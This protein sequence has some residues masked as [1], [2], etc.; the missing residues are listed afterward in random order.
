MNPKVFSLKEANL[1]IPR[2]DSLTTCLLTK[3]EKMQ[4]KHDQLL[5]LDLIAGEKVHNPKTNDGKDYLTKSAEL[6]ALILSFEDDILE[7]NK[8]G[9]YLR[10][11][12]KG[13]VDFFS[14]QKNELIYL[15]WQRGEER[16]SFYHDVDAHFSKRKNLELP[17]L[18]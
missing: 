8:L 10:D 14:I 16:V 5:V 1:M 3:K 18:D 17:F 6:E 11:I 15:N 13:S 12:E 2:L 4:K 7:I 9:C